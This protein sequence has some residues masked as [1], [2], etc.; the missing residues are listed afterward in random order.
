VLESDIH[1]LVAPGGKERTDAEY[2]APG[3][4]GLGPNAPPAGA[5]AVLP[6]RGR[7]RVTGWQN[8]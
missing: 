7:A 1:M 4:R 6:D 8:T 2:R 3:R 5:A